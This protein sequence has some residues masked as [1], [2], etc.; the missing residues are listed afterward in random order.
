[1]RCTGPYTRVLF[2]KSDAKAARALIDGLNAYALAVRHL[3]Q[4]VD[5]LED[6]ALDA[7]F[8]APNASCGVWELRAAKYLGPKKMLGR[9]HVYDAAVRH[10]DATGVVLWEGYVFAPSLKAL[11]H[12]LT[13]VLPAILAGN[14]PDTVLNRDDA[15]IHRVEL[16]TG[17]PL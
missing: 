10:R 1:M 17:E 7:D 12:A 8:P 14:A 11:G 5:G 2:D 15:E 13:E 9:S 4:G 16:C 3:P 6:F